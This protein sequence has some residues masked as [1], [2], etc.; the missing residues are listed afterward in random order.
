LQ[1]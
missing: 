1:M